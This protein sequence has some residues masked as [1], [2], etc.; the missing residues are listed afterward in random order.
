MI[1]KFLSPVL[2]C[3]FFCLVCSNV[4]AQKC[5]DITIEELTSKLENH[6]L[7]VCQKGKIS[8]QDEHGIQP[9]LIQIKKKG[10]K[11]AMVVDKVIG[12]AAALLMVYGKVKQVHTNIIA[13]DAI[14]VFEKHK[15]KYSY[16]E[17][18]DYIQNAKQDGLCPMEQKVLNIDSP[19]KAYKI[20]T[21][22]K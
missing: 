22:Q 11:K 5:A 20:F 14:E 2:V 19:K 9:L 4:F 21:K 1:K 3:L 13:K 15:V 17:V 10:L 6:S 7:A 16:N 12:K 8:F 18:V